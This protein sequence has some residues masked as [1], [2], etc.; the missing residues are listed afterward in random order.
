MLSV[1]ATVRQRQDYNYHHRR[2]AEG[3][4]KRAL[5]LATLALSLVIMDTVVISAIEYWSGGQENMVDILFEVV[6]RPS[7][8]WACPPAL[9]RGCT[10]WQN[11]C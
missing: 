11:S 5:A 10:M 9:R 3:L 1:I 4:V 7:V 6:S 8:R 2:L